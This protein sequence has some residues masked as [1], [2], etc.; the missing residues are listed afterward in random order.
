MKKMNI[1]WCFLLTLC[2]GLVHAQKT[3]KIDLSLWKLSIPEGST[4][5]FKAPKLLD[6]ANDKDIQKY[7]FNDL[8]D[9]SLVFYSFPS[10][11]SKRPYTKTELKEQN[12]FGSDIGWTFKEGAKLKIV[13]RMGDISKKNDKNP[14]VIFVQIG[15][16]ISD[17]QANLI[18]ASDNDAPAILKVYWD[19][20]YIKLRS[21]KLKNGV[22]GNDIYREDS[23]EDDDGYTFKDK[24]DQDKFTFEIEI[25]DGK[26]EVTL[27][28]RETKEY[29][30][31]NYQKWN[32]FDNY[33]TVGCN[34]QS[35]EV[36]SFAN[37]KFYT[38]E[39]TH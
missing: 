27:N 24:V 5:T 25:T 35:E 15:G 12:S 6:Y 21:K 11:K 30:G 7:M 32:N 36:G 37:M 1:C 26:M 22:V 39:V 13:A 17:D 31:I 2:M 8:N 20:G 28:K 34:L 23:W 4:K 14:R 9:K 18:G 19:N 10:I 3:P 16:R 38:L 29:S 33:F